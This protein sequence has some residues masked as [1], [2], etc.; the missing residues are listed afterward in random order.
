VLFRSVAEYGIGFF[1]RIRQGLFP[2]FA[3][4]GLIDWNDVGMMR[5]STIV[6]PD[7]TTWHGHEPD[8]GRIER[9]INMFVRTLREFRDN[10]SRYDLSRE[11]IAKVLDFG[12]YL[13]GH[14]NS[15]GQID[16]D[17]L[18]DPQKM[19]DILSFIEGA[20]SVRT[21]SSSE[22]ETLG[23]FKRRLS[24]IL[25]SSQEE[26]HSFAEGGLLGGDSHANGG[27][28]IEAEKG[29][30]IIPR[31]AVSKLGI[32]IM[33]SIRRG[34]LPKFADGG[35]IGAPDFSGA[36]NSIKQA[37]SIPRFADGGMVGAAQ[38]PERVV[39]VDFNIGRQTFSGNFAEDQADAFLGILAREKA[40]AI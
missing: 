12:N 13:T 39:Q 30:Y 4:G 10:P 18:P 27:T 16:K 28:L 3:E 22:R 17:S 25:E 1:E 21:L 20:G 37:T 9:L 14:L 34:I 15:S 7:G 32:G 36:F 23:V 31:S 26:Y 40:L 11:D 35:W 19:Y 2:K 8:A 29:E 24:E 38:R 6:N 33:E 5:L